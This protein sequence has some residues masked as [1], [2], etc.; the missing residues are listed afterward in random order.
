MTGN[1]KAAQ[2]YDT[3]AVSNGE[4]IV[5]W[6]NEREG[7]NGKDK[8]ICPSVSKSWQDKDKK[9]QRQNVNLNMND[10]YRLFS[11]VTKVKEIEDK[12][13]EERKSSG[14]SDPELDR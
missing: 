1:N 4:K 7:K 5:F 8:Q 10:L 3:I 9:W 13:K 12:F 11:V 14:P 6:E 2:P